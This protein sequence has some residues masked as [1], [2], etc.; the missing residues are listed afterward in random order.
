MTLSKYAL[1]EQAVQCP[2][3][4]VTHFP[5]FHL[6]LTGKE[7]LRLREDFCGTGAISLAWI[8]KSPKH[9]AVGLDLDREPLA[10]AAKTHHD[11]LP[12]ADRKRIELRRQDVLK[13]TKDKFDLV[14]ACNFSFFIFQERA[15]LLAYARAVRASLKPKGT[16]FLEMAGGEGMLEALEEERNFSMPGL[17]KVK[18]VWDQ[19]E[20]DPIQARSRYAIHFQLPN[21]KWLKNQ[22]TYDWRLWGIRE[23]RE[24]LEEAGFS[25]TK[26]IWETCDTKGD[27]TGEYLPLESGDH[28]HAWVAYVVGVK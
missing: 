19:G 6:W 9:S 5:R 11:K 27:G 12:A 26:V 2:D 18:Y 25:K 13:P 22:F 14:C 8:A 7:A 15:K 4:H 17:G 16:F 28:A 20:Y 10:Y 3:W 24:I 23:V 1:Y 21:G